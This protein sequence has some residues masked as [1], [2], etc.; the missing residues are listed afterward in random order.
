MVRHVI[1]IPVEERTDGGIRLKE[2]ALIAGI[3]TDIDGRGEGYMRVEVA[4]MMKPYFL[5]IANGQFFSFHKYN[6]RVLRGKYS[7]GLYMLLKSYQRFKVLQ[8]DYGELRDILEILP[9][10]YQPFKAFKRWVLERTRQEMLEKNDIYFDY[11]EVRVGGSK[12]GEVT[13]IIFHIKENPSKTDFFN[14]LKQRELHEPI[15]TFRKSNAKEYER[16]ENS[17]AVFTESPLFAT[18]EQAETEG[19]FTRAEIINLFRVFDKE[20]SEDV[21]EIFLDGLN[22]KGFSTERILDVLYYAQEKQTKGEKIRNIMGYMKTGLESGIMGLGLAK[23]K[24]DG[25]KKNKSNKQIAA[26][27]ESTEFKTYL[28]NYYINKGVEADN[29]IKL[30]FVESA[31]TIKSM[32]KYFDADGR[33]KDMYKDKFREA[34]GQRLAAQDDETADNIFVRWAKTEKN[35]SVEKV[36][37]QWRFRT[38]AIF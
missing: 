38:E 36:G 21:L 33:L 19:G 11:E 9:E 1:N 35:L 4:E 18:A 24:R 10:E 2:V 23:A 34:L 3:D 25:G 31:K 29:D 14:K 26:F 5:E 37:G 20:T 27:F 12:R 8:M 6:S 22:A 7:I 28:Q 17:E 32:M 30:A 15:V 13:K 16:G